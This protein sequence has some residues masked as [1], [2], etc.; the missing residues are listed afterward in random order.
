MNKD[1][2][3][4]PLF[5]TP[6][7]MK[8]EAR[9]GDARREY[10]YLKILTG[11]L[12]LVLLALI[13]HRRDWFMDIPKA[14]D[15]RA[16]AM[17]AD[18]V[19]ADTMP[20]QEAPS[21]RPGTADTAA[22]EKAGFFSRLLARIQKSPAP[23]PDEIFL[24]DAPIDSLCRN[25]GLE[26]GAVRRKIK[27]VPKY[28]VEERLLLPKGRPMPE[29]VLSLIRLAESRGLK[30]MDV[31]E[32]GKDSSVAL[33]IWGQTKLLRKLTL[34]YGPYY[35]P[36]YARLAFVLE[37]FGE[38]FSQDISALFSGIKRPTTLGLV[39]QRAFT[40]RIYQLALQNGFEVLC[41]IP[42]ENIPFRDLGENAVYKNSGKE[43]IESLLSD[44]N[45]EMPEAKGYS[46]F[47]GGIRIVENEP[48]ILKTVMA[49]IKSGEGCFIDN[50]FASRSRV[51]EFAR[52]AGVT[53]LV[54]LG[55]ADEGDNAAKPEE[56]VLKYAGIVRK[57]GKG[58]I[59]LRD[60][61]HA[62]KVLEKTIPMIESYGIKLVTVSS[63][64]K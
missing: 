53:L 27:D 1:T 8:N 35:L 21:P 39:P 33:E 10:L 42:M 14:P 17:A 28:Y 51:E 3:F 55:C 49:H 56:A 16:A 22:P 52:E 63:L 38:T 7:R 45:Q 40:G 6:N 4:S 26:K 24:L 64:I 57:T 18:T 59:L 60:I 61:P 25:L 34:A 48:E 19:T 37:G 23:A 36:G 62:G 43:K 12:C 11:V 9:G 32:S 29:Y 31:W 50:S 41:Q 58:I 30:V 15:A 5:K 44:F 47:G 13:Y 46:I 20:Q 2:R 54:P